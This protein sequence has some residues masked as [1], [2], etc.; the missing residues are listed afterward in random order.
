MGWQAEVCAEEKLTIFLEAIAADR[1]PRPIRI[2]GR[3]GR[4]FWE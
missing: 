4:E 2:G 1:R 3:L